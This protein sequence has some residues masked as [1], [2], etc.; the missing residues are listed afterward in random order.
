MVFLE[1]Y[2]KK[3]NRLCHHHQVD[4]L[5][6]FGSAATN[7]HTDLSDIDLLVTFKKF[8]LANYFTNYVNL[9]EKLEKLFNRKVDLIES[10]TLRNPILISS[11]S[12]TKKKIYGLED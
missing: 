1:P 9:K 8:N 12:K 4:N 5:Y 2:K 11:I 10:Q 6:I 3:L 7:N